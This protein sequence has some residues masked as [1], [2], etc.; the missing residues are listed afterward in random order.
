MVAIVA[1][2]D[3]SV[4]VMC[5]MC[6]CVCMVF[7]CCAKTDP[8]LLRRES[9]DKPG[10]FVGAAAWPPDIW[11]LQSLSTKGKR[12]EDPQIVA[13]ANSKV[14]GSKIRSFADPTLSTGVFLL[15]VHEATASKRVQNEHPSGGYVCS[16][17]EIK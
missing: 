13:W 6:V 8:C 4:C 14:D 17:Y 1:M 15:K 12:I 9:W 10:R 2:V 5:V 3:V 7:V 11:R 16:T